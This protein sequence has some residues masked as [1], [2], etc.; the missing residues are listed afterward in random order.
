MRLKR[1][2]VHALKQLK[3]LEYTLKALLADCEQSD[4]AVLAVVEEA[5]RVY[6]DFL[7]G[8]VAMSVSTVTLHK[9]RRLQ[10]F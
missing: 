3:G 2:V 6:I 5:E 7:E 8:F 10:T 4:A 1:N 9:P